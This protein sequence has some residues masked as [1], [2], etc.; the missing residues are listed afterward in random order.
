MNISQP[1]VSTGIAISQFF[2][3]KAHEMEN[4]CMEIMHMHFSVS[5]MHAEVIGITVR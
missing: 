1:E 2:M 5:C 4:G 3:I